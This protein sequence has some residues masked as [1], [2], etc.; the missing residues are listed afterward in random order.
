[1]RGAEIQLN[2]AQS[3][4]QF[5]LSSAGGSSVRRCTIQSSAPSEL[6]SPLHRQE[7]HD[8]LCYDPMNRCSLCANRRSRI[9]DSISEAMVRDINIWPTPEILMQ[10]DV[11]VLA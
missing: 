9:D 11:G 1:M 6:P 2:E 8:D 4:E 10:P 5:A 3:P 7:H